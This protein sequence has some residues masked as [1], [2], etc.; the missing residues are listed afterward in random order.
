MGDGSSIRGSLGQKGGFFVRGF[1]KE[2]LIDLPVKSVEARIG[3]SEKSCIL[4]FVVESTEGVFSG[5]LGSANFGRKSGFTNREEPVL[6]GIWA[7]ALKGKS[8]VAGASRLR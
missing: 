5:Q 7:K 1:A 6:T 2:H 3:C 8:V 4:L